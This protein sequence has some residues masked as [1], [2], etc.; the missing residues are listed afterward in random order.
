MQPLQHGKNAK[1]IHFELEDKLRN[2]RGDAAVQC[3]PMKI[4]M[5]Q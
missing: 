3:I 5:L 1:Q 4:S 2:L